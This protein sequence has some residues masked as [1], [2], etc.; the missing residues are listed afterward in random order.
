MIE[1][2]GKQYELVEIS[3]RKFQ[4]L[5]DRVETELGAGW[6]SSVFKSAK[7][8]LWLLACCLK[9]AGGNFVSE[10]ELL[11]IPQ[12]LIVEYFNQAIKLGGL[13]TDSKESWEKN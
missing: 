11:D 1:I 9:S 5:M 3:A 10:D 8:R 13:D 4:A 2:A 7:Y 6:E 12:R